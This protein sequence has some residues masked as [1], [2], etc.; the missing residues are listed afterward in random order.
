MFSLSWLNSL[1]GGFFIATT[2]RV[3]PECLSLADAYSKT[4]YRL[5][6]PTCAFALGALSAWGVLAPVT[7]MACSLSSPRS[8]LR[9]H[10]LHNESFSENSFENCK[11]PRDGPYSLSYFSFP[12]HHP[13]IIYCNY[14]LFC[15]C[16]IHHEGKTFY[17]FYYCWISI[18]VLG[19]R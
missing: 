8:L 16:R 7:H 3:L 11:R 10:P 13:H 17:Q 18:V 14:F 12:D 5:W 2:K 15:L 1:V 9:C 19:T 6:Q 4:P